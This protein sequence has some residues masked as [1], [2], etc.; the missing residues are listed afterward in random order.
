MVYLWKLN[1]NYLFNGTQSTAHHVYP[2]EIEESLI[3]PVFFCVRKKY[4]FHCERITTTYIFLKH[5]NDNICSLVYIIHR[6]MFSVLF[7]SSCDTWLFFF[8]CFMHILLQDSSLLLLLYF[9]INNFFKISCRAM[10]FL[11]THTHII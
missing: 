3:L 11:L 10:L 9:V 1:R 7:L 8:V 4:Q 2:M 5:Y 6:K